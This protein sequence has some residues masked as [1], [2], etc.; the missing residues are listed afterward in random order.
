MRIDRVYL[1]VTV[2]KRTNAFRLM[3]RMP[4]LKQ[5][6]FAYF[7]SVE[8][9]I[10]KWL[11]RVYEVNLPKVL[12]PRPPHPKILEAMVELDTVTKVIDKL[13]ER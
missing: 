7:I 6:E 4:K 13:T 3:K 2:N 12:P 5:N 11:N 9:D 10:E 8:L 1:V